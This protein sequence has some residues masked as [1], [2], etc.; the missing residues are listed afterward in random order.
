MANT[1]DL[2]NI[3]EF[4]ESAEELVKKVKE[5]A[6]LIQAAKKVVFFTGA[7]ISTAASIPDYRGPQ[8]VWTRKAQ[9]KPGPKSISFES[10]IPTATHMA[11]KT[12]LEDTGSKC[13]YLISQ[14]VDGLHRRSGIKR[15]KISELHGNTFKEICWSC[16]ADFMRRKEV[17]GRLNAPGTC[18]ECLKKVPYFC[19]CTGRVCTEC[20][21]RLKDSII[22]FK[23]NLPESAL[24]SGFK[25][26]SEADLH[27]VLGSSL[28]V[29]P[30]CEM[31]RSTH[32]H[33]GKLVVINLQKTPLDGLCSV[34]IFA[35]TD[36]V[37]T[38]LMEKLGL[39]IHDYV[40]SLKDDSR[41]PV[42][43][44]ALQIAVGT[45]VQIIS[46]EENGVITGYIKKDDL[47]RVKLNNEQQI[48]RKV[49]KFNMKVRD[50]R[51]ALDIL[52][53]SAADVDVTPS[54]GHFA[55]HLKTCE[56]VKKINAGELPFDTAKLLK[57]PCA[58]CKNEQENM[59]CMTCYTVCCGR[60]VKQHM[61]QHH[62]K[63][64]H[65][66][67]LGTADLSFWCYPCKNYLSTD[68]N[69][70]GYIYNEVHKSKFNEPA[71]G[72]AN[73]NFGNVANK[74]KTVWPQNI[75][76]LWQGVATLNP[77]STKSTE[78]RDIK[79][80]LSIVPKDHKPNIFGSG[81]VRN[82]P[83]PNAVT[84]PEVSMYTLQGKF[85]FKTGK[86]LFNKKYEEMITKNVIGNTVYEAQL[87]LV[88]GVW[89][90]TG[91]WVNEKS[92]SFGTF[93]C[94]REA[95]TL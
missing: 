86:C 55:P 63:T 22:H 85:D 60:H 54:L 19:H 36:E 7:G 52:D 72:C 9:K 20:G 38:K 6:K 57:A 81:Y 33:G 77:S 44:T 94:M 47:W 71:P 11:L 2:N 89:Q 45:L 70:L 49:A 5:L 74:K 93:A 25:H 68:S 79:W 16:D 4:E 80:S 78:L 3:K 37:M 27:I 23:E 29:S 84:L 43:E 67:V 24:V 51:K 73:R 40:D 56:H 13:Q 32:T 14:N 88:D 92:K 61:V 64:K 39:S 26:S 62:E 69:E 31:P 50:E 10:A 75:S 91:T 59:I 46:T 18:R 34:R 48:V 95:R 28:R 87:A 65:P 76:G 35:K 1:V 42:E 83:R 30:A 90:L 66:I 58:I 21:C 15:E 17:R 53:A 41:A 82:L 8:G 12:L